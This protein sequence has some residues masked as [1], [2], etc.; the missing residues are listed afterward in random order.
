MSA[1]DEKV[2]KTLDFNTDHISDPVKFHISLIK[3]F[4][5]KD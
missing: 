3:W 1:D 5:C 4:Y 2:I